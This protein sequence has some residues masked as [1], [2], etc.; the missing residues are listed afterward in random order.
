[1]LAAM[2][3]LVLSP[4]A[5]QEAAAE[6]IRQWVT[7]NVAGHE[8]L[9]GQGN[10]VPIPGL[11]GGRLVFVL[12]EMLRGRRVSPEREGL[13]HLVGMALLV[14]MVLVITYYDILNPVNVDFSLR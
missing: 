8:R 7:K 13:I 1:M 10:P 12:L 2:M 14:S 4:P 9:A 3:L 5:D 6:Q 11:D